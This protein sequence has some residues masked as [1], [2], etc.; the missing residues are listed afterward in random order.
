MTTLKD[1][2]TSDWLYKTTDFTQKNDDM[3][4]N[5]LFDLM[6]EFT[7]FVFSPEIAKEIV[8]YI[9]L[10]KNR[11]STQKPDHFGND[12]GD[13]KKSLYDLMNMIVG[14]F[15]C[16]NA[17]KDQAFSSLNYSNEPTYMMMTEYEIEQNLYEQFI[18]DAPTFLHDIIFNHGKNVLKQS[19]Q[20]LENRLI[21]M[22][23]T[24]QYEPVLWV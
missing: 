5:D 24:K 4:E 20:I 21:E 8:I 22:I 3:S 1:F 19:I 7:A 16:Q 14:N 23:K 18:L 11:V 6:E 9:S 15:M 12:E 17:D 2:D 10:N 13:Y